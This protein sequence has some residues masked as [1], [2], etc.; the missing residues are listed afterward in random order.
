MSHRPTAR[1][2]RNRAV[3]RL[4]PVSVS[5]VPRRGVHPADRWPSPRRVRRVA[6]AVDRRG[7]SPHPLVIAHRGASGYRPEHTLAGYELAARLGADF[8]EPD[9]VSTADGVLVAR[10]EP[11]IG[12]TTDIAARPEFAGRRT[13]KTVDGHARTG[14]FVEDLTLAELTTL[15]AVERIPWVRPRNAAYDGRFAVP[16]FAEILALRARLSTELGREIGVYPETKHPSYHVAIG[17]ALEPALVADLADAGLNHAGA[18]VFV[19]SFETGSLRVLRG[20]TPVPLVQLLDHRGGPADLAGTPSARSYADLCTPGGLAG[21][22][23]YAAAIGP[24]KHLVIPRDPAGSLG[25]PTTLVAD[26]HT[27]GLLVHAW[28]FRDEDRYLPAPVRTS[29]ARSRGGA[30]AEYAAF[31][32]AGVDGVFSDHPDTAV[33]ARAALLTAAAS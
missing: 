25:D 5:R 11:E 22:A 13:T 23:R 14:W 29:P 32:R 21:V 4:G 7:V 6:V 33:A 3:S 20:M 28:T 8:L 18:P 19:Q 16:T 30:A 2:H 12:A 1:R 10:H 27:A 31:L 26:A 24:D 17:L 9:L 15:R